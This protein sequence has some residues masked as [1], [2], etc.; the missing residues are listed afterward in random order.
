M[1]ITKLSI[2]QFLALI[3]LVF[4][5]FNTTSCV[6]DNQL[7]SE[8]ENFTLE[9][10]NF[11]IVTLDFP[12]NVIITKG[13]VQSININAQPEVF[14]AITKTVT[15]DEWLIDLVNFNDGFESVTIEI[16]IPII[17]GLHTTS[18]GDIQVQDQ[19]DRVESL[20]LSVQSTGS[21]QHQGD[22]Q[23]IDLLINGTGDV[24]LAGEADFLNARLNSTGSLA[25]FDL[26]TQEVV[27]V[28]TSTG[29][30]EI[31]VAQRLEVTMTSTG[32]VRYKGTPQIISNISGTGG[33]VDEN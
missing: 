22:A 12:A 18:T 7:T 13:A 19:F 11:S 2:N 31:R 26:S 15:D 14:D 4:F 6:E 8:P 17:T 9:L 27:L 29:D 32:D 3:V 25:A 16:T 23:Q 30:A 21:I 20:D 28:S 1:K 10:P 5:A 24:T 33:L